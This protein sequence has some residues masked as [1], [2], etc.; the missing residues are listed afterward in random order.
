VTQDL[1]SRGILVGDDSDP[2][3]DYVVEVDELRRPCPRARRAQ[4]GPMAQPPGHAHGRIEALLRPIG[5][6]TTGMD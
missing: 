2:A 5:Q 3:I 4:P 1:Y 6:S